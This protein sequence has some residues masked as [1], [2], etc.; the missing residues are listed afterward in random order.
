M[1]S[2]KPKIVDSPITRM[3][4]AWMEMVANKTSRLMVEYLKASTDVRKPIDTLNRVHLGALAEIACSTYIG[5]LAKRR[6]RKEVLPDEEA[7]LDS[8]LG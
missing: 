7:Q 6:A 2:K 3:E 1:K 8:W 4:A 5:E